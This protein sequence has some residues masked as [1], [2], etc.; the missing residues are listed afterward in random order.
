MIRLKSM[1]LAI[2][3]PAAR[4]KKPVRAVVAIAVAISC[5]FYYV[6]GLQ[7]VSSGFVIILASVAASAAGTWLF[8]IKEVESGD[9]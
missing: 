2:I 1:P 3:L 8:P 4:E 7:K 5:L 9:Q 6:P